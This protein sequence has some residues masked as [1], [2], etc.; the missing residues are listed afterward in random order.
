MIDNQDKTPSGS[1]PGPDGVTFSKPP[2]LIGHRGAM[3]VAP[4]NTIASFRR[5][6]ADGADWIEFDVRLSGDGVPII[7][8]DDTLERTSDGVGPVSS[9]ALAALKALDAGRWFAPA[10][11]GEPIPTFLET[12]ILCRDLGLGMNIEIKPSPGEERETASAALAMLDTVLDHH[13]QATARSVV[14]SSFKLEALETLRDEGSRW[15][16][17][18]LISQWPADWR[19]LVTRLGCV[20]LHPKADLLE[21]RHMTRTIKDEGLLIFP[22]TVND[23]GRS[24]ELFD[25]GVDAVITDDPRLLGSS[26]R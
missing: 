25:W 2:R 4:E 12:I 10:F 15:P 24:S 8:H 5:A 9:H 19:E 14:F 13:D 6:A 26:S 1:R 16:R 20:S 23:P 17:G 7:F 11:S 21:S 3:A 18:L 22:Y